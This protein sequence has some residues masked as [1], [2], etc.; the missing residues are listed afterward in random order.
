MKWVPTDPTTR[1]AYTELVTMVSSVVASAFVPDPSEQGLRSAPPPKRDRFY[2]D[3]PAN[4][5]YAHSPFPDIGNC[6]DLGIKSAFEI[7]DLDTALFQI[8]VVLNPL[9]VAAQKWSSILSVS[10]RCFMLPRYFV[11]ILRDSG[12]PM[13]IT[14]I[15]TWC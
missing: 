10:E 11:L 13:P 6:V 1:T 8:G 2:A 9:S 15:H 7:G 12:Y 3:L 14:C 5:R 4:H